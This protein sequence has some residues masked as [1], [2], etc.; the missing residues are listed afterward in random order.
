MAPFVLK[1]FDLYMQEI[2][3]LVLLFVISCT[4]L[5]SRSL[6]AKSVP[7]PPTAIPD[8]HTPP[9]AT[10]STA[11][12]GLLKVDRGKRN[13]SSHDSSNYMIPLD[14]DSKA[15]PESPD[16]QTA[17]GSTVANANEPSP[18]DSINDGNNWRC[19]CEGGFLPPGL[20]KTFGGAEAVM[21]LGSGQCY[22]KQV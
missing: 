8:T 14:G 20:L 6:A 9:P 17:T 21:R 5:R 12:N 13:S 22:H 19:A 7:P 10:N 15:K 18:A 1:E 11:G 2:I 4:F 3:G 16:R